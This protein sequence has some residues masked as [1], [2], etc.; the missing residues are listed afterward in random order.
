MKKLILAAFVMMGV[1]VAAFAQSEK[2]F[3]LSVGAELGLATGSFSG[4]HSVGT[5]VTAQAEVSLMDKLKGTA[6]FGV[7][8]YAGKSVD[9]IGSSVKY[10]YS[11]QTILPLRVG[12]KY[13]LTQG[14]YAGAQLGVAFLGNYASGTAFAYSP[15]MVGYE[16]KTKSDK[17]IDAT[18]KY[19]AY[20]GSNG[21]GTIGTFGARLAYVF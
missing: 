4:S 20:T 14:I 7:L 17:A 21:I 10:K 18:I 5:G 6:T 1:S 13:F 11:G 8:A 19:D 2:N 3:S 15:L 16:F 12:A 9:L